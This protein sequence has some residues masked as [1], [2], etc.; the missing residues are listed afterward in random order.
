M[1]Y[2]EA[3]CCLG[4]IANCLGAITGSL[5]AILMSLEAIADC[6][7][8]IRVSFGTSADSLGAVI[9][10]SAGIIGG[11]GASAVMGISSTERRRPNGRQAVPRER[12]N[13]R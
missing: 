13:R 6:L 7:G 8:V 2:Y 9:R 10:A 1:G 5:G 12:P 4:S 11:V 3:L